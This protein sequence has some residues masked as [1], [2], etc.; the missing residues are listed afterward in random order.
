MKNMSEKK[1][2]D[3][4]KSFL[5]LI[6]RYGEIELEGL[7]LQA[8]DLEITVRPGA[9]PTDLVMRKVLGNAFAQLGQTLIGGRVAMPTAPTPTIPPAV[10]KPT[11]PSP[12]PKPTELPELEFSSPTQKYPSSIVEVTLGATKSDGG[13]RGKTVTIGGENMPAFHIFEGEQR[14][15]P[16]VAGDVFDMYPGFPSPVKK[17]F[18]DTVENPIEWAKLWVDKFG[19]DI[20]DLELISTDPYI[21]DTP[22]AE[23]VKLVEDI[24][25]AVDVPLMIG[26]SGNPEKDAKLLP[27]VAEVCEGERVLLSSATLDMWEPVAKAAK[28]HKQLVL[29]WTSIDLNQAKELN[30]KLF[31]YIPIEQIVMDPT[32]AALGYGLEYA[33][34]VMERIRLAAIMGDK[35]L[36]CP[37][38]SGTAN[39]WGAREAWKKDPELGPRPYRGPLWEATGAIAFLLAGIDLFIMLHPGAVRTLKDII[40]WIM[41]EKKPPTFPELI[42]V[43]K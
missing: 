8:K 23:S 5:D 10:P 17:S 16:I 24:L 36:Q 14:H 33:F 20:I 13:T 40:G 39:S 4:L 12:P 22:I 6:N 3:L 1:E 41:G 7:S 35:E 38:G 29:A 11:P 18:G 28:E 2:K 42:G 26:G 15:P 43:G 34:T 30:R 31:D 21:K 27:K 32:S 25:Q 9:Q 37:Q 19:A